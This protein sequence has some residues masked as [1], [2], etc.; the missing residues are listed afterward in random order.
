MI[1]DEV[2][3]IEGRSQEPFDFAQGR[4]RL[5][6][7]SSTCRVERTGVRIQNDEQG[8]VESRRELT[9]TFNIPCWIF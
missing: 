2:S 6:M 4:E 5:D 9:S 8:T 1:D 3:R 7:S